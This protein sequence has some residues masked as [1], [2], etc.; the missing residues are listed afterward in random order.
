MGVSRIP[1][2]LL[3]VL[4]LAALPVQ[5]Q[6]RAEDSAATYETAFVHAGLGAIERWEREVYGDTSRLE[7]VDL[8][9][10]LMSL[11]EELTRLHEVAKLPPALPRIKRLLSQYQVPERYGFAAGGMLAAGIQRMDLKNEAFAGYSMF[12]VRMEN[13][14]GKPLDGGAAE[15]VLHLLGGGQMNAEVISQSHELYPQ[16][17][18]ILSRFQAPAQIA[19]AA[20]ASFIAAFPQP[21]LEL[22][23]LAYVTVTY[24]DFRF[25]IKCYENL[26]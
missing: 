2:I 21:G 3:T 13:R 9:V 18:R 4:I 23:G 5:A 8:N 22:G 7:Q 6:P 24:G 19:P 25:V 12:L 11:L 26:P 14:A 10:K 15:V 1:V 16:V 20:E 17:S